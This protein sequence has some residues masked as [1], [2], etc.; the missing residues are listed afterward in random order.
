MVHEGEGET[1]RTANRAL[2]T[3]NGLRTNPTETRV[4]APASRFPCVV[5]FGRTEPFPPP[6][7]FPPAELEAESVMRG[8]GRTK[9]AERAMMVRTCVREVM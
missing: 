6:F 7:I 8:G 5:N 3:E 2:S 9:Y 4:S 1:R